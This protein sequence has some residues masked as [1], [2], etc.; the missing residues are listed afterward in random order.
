MDVDQAPG[1]AQPVELLDYLGE[2]VPNSMLIGIVVEAF[3]TPVTASGDTI[4]RVGTFDANEARHGQGR[5]G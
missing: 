4:E 5:M 3:F 2:D 1:V